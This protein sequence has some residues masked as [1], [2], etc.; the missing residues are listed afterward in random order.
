MTASVTLY[1]L[2]SEETDVVVAVDIED[3][4]CFTY[5]DNQLCACQMCIYEDG[6]CFFRQ[7]EDHLTE[8]HLKGNNY[9][10][11]T[12]EEGIIRFDAKVVDFN[13]N[14]DILEMHYILNDEERIIRINYY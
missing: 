2:D 9:A 14:D 1:N 11:I 8:L 6:I 7:A 10:K 4:N 3:R 13:I 12:T 5:I